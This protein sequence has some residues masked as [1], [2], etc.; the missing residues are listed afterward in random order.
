MGVRVY[1]ENML[2]NEN[3]N[4]ALK[5]SHADEVTN[6]MEFVQVRPKVNTHMRVV[7]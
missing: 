7:S 5:I 1:Y 6:R 2:R 4:R 3:Q